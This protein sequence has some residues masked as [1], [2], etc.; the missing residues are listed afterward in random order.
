VVRDKTNAWMV[1]LGFVL[2]VII[3]GLMIVATILVL[4]NKI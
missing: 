1:G 2:L 3:L 4:T